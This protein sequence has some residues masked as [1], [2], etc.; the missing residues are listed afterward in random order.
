MIRKLFRPKKPAQQP[1]QERLLMD[2][3]PDSSPFE[4]KLIA[5]TRQT[6]MTSPERLLATIRAIDY[7]CDNSIP[8][9]IVECGV[10]RGGNVYAAA[11]TLARH[12]DFDR[13]IWLYDTFEGMTTPTRVDV[14]FLGRTAD[15]L[16][17][18][19]HIDDPQGVWC[20]CP[21]EGVRSH[22]TSSGYPETR[23]LFVQGKVE[24]TLLKSTPEQIALLRLDTDW[25][26]STKCEL[27]ILFPK[28]VNGG[29]LIIDDY[30]H[31]QGCR[32]AVEEYI[33]Q[34]NIQLFLNRID[35]TGRMAI[36]QA[37]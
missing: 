34:N 4:R 28:L 23:F 3:L 21:L 16:M 15:D 9:D 14:D 22:V 6:T 25:Y 26:E 19:D 10:W 31:W 29:V 8:G 37:A 13:N 11:K 1:S 32:R 2:Q 7:I 33:A 5:E 12:Q 17:I 20:R 18:I 35:Y 24:E 30:G 27:E 36:K